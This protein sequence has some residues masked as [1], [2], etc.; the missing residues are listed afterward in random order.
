MS[1][2]RELGCFVF[3]A[4]LDLFSDFYYVKHTLRI[5]CCVNCALFLNLLSGV[6]F[7]FIFADS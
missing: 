1:Y 6:D 2:L 7:L 3:N 4:R 5:M